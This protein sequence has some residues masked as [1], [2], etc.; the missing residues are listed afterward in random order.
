MAPQDVLKAK[1]QQSVRNPKQLYAEK[2]N[3]N[4]GT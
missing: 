3:F 2:N 4:N 1:V